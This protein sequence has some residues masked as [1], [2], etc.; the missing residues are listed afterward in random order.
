MVDYRKT[1]GGIHKQAES[2]HE[3]S[4]ILV[5]HLFPGKKATARFILLDGNYHDWAAQTVD[6]SPP[7][8]V[9]NEDED[10][11]IVDHNDCT[12]ALKDEIL[13]VTFNSDV[14]AFIPVG[15]SGLVRQAIV[16]DTIDY[17]DSGDVFLARCGT[18]IT[19]T[20]TVTAHNCHNDSESDVAAGS[21]VV[22]AY[23]QGFT[24]NTVYRQG[25]W[26]IVSSIGGGE[27]IV[28]QAPR[29]GIEA[30]GVGVGN[31]QFNSATCKVLD[32]SS[33]GFYSDSGTTETIYNMSRYKSWMGKNSQASY[34]RVGIARKIGSIWVAEPDD[35]YH[36]AH[37]WQGPSGSFNPATT[38]IYDK[39][40]PLVYNGT[41]LRFDG[42]TVSGNL[43]DTSS[44]I[45]IDWQQEL[46]VTY[47]T[48]ADCQLYFYLTFLFGGVVC[49]SRFYAISKP[50]ST[51]SNLVHSY[52]FG[53]HFFRNVTSSTNLQPTIRFSCWGVDRGSMTIV[54]YNSDF[55][56]WN[57]GSS[58]GTH[59]NPGGGS[60]GSG[61][62]SFI[63]LA[64]N[65][66]E[67]DNTISASGVVVAPA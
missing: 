22:I 62:A 18:Q 5:E 65:I 61:T 41:Y 9:F 40:L 14:G 52:R 4:V 51:N 19:P 33:N 45:H 16:D 15:S 10:I 44:V 46:V 13:K 23:I 53:G 49:D 24:D 27:F 21:K 1:S 66:A 30:A 48:T 56:L 37:A 55:T 32:V 29:G 28:F 47:T 67:D 63:G 11:T 35:E 64:D 6:T 2:H 20:A 60:G 34:D 42:S 39:N 7:M 54:M 3:W 17:G 12:C 50:V 36:L 57:Y 38:L 26:Q 25:A 31:S 59:T 8:V 43:Q 58:Y